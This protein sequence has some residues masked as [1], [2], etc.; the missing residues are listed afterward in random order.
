MARR[1]E[2]LPHCL[3]KARIASDVRTQRSP[4]ATS[5][6]S[7]ISCK[8]VE[9]GHPVRMRTHDSRNGPT[10][11]GFAVNLQLAARAFMEPS[12]VALGLAVTL[13]ELL[14]RLAQAG[15]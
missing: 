3:T 13:E 2:E 11:A 4:R 10:V 5:Q 15:P 8:L 7:Q 14:K 12:L 9:G 6:S 1:G